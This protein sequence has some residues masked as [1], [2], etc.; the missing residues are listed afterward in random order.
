MSPMTSHLIGS[1]STF[2]QFL[3]WINDQPSVKLAANASTDAVSW[4]PSHDPRA[5]HSPSRLLQVAL[6]MRP[7]ESRAERPVESLLNH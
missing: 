2:D 7:I 3:L 6:A 1:S 4:W 5:T